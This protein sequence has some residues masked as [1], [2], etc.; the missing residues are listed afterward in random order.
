MLDVVDC[1]GIK[2]SK[3]R[4]SANAFVKVRCTCF[5]S[6]HSLSRATMFLTASPRELSLVKVTG[7]NVP[8]VL[9]MWS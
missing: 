2:P 4:K 1:I 8:E 5:S 6:K 3:N 7:L 9:L